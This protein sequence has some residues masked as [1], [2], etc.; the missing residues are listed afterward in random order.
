MLIFFLTLAASARALTLEEI[1]DLTESQTR[2]LL[3]D[4]SSRFMLLI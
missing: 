2:D 4:W 1:G 3:R